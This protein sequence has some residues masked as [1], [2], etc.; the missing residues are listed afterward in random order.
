MSINLKLPDVS[1]QLYENEVFKNLEENWHDFGYDWM[2]HQLDYVNTIY[3]AYKDHSKFLI[4]IYLINKTLSFYE[5]NYVMLSYEKYYQQTTIEIEKF[6]VIE[7]SKALMLPKETARRKIKELEN[8][9]VIK[10]DKKNLIIDK[11]AFPFVQPI[12]SIPR[13]SRFIS[14]FTNTLVDNQQ[15][16]RNINTDDIE[17]KIKLNFTYIWKNYYELQ[18]DMIKGWCALFGDFSTWHVY[19]TCVVSQGYALKKKKT[20]NKSRENFNHSLSKEKYFVGINAMSI[21]E[22]TG[23][24]RA[25]TV[26]KLGNLVKNE[27]LFINEKKQYLI[28]GKKIE[29]LNKIQLKVIKNLSTFITKTLNKFII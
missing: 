29:E 10:R 20:N 4:I 18:L 11:T 1:K 13:I 3:A 5:R 17:K 23:I 22:L 21:A 2:S 14:K 16:E 6:N 27:Y 28:T 26:R 12:K 8:E 19:G 15:L 9:G 7:I 25:T 24:P